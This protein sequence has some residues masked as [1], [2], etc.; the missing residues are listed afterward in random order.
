MAKRSIIW[1][2]TA[3]KQRRAILNY[4]IKR[5]HSVKFAQKLIQEIKERSKI[6]AQN[7]EAFTTADYPETRISAMGH[8]SILY[9]ITDTQIIITAFWDNRQNPQKLLDLLTKNIR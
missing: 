3:V 8:Y 1:T 2:Q 9:K 4:W 7:P 6:I 5:N